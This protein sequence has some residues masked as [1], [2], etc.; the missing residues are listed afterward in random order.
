MTV[1]ANRE[2]SGRLNWQLATYFG[3]DTKMSAHIAP[4]LRSHVAERLK[5]DAKIIAAMKSGQQRGYGEAK[6]ETGDG[7]VGSTTKRVERRAPKGNGSTAPP[8]P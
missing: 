2:P 3:L 4:T 1:Y 8:K 6:K 7:S 5:G